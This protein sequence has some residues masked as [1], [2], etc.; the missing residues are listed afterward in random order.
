MGLDGKAEKKYYGSGMYLSKS[1]FRYRGT[2]KMDGGNR[3]CGWAPRVRPD[4]SKCV[5]R[6]PEVFNNTAGCKYMGENVAK[7]MTEV[8]TSVDADAR[9]KEWGVK[10]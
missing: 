2:G 9:F 4:D 1:A 10:G 5:A 7:N 8:G 6:S 3:Q